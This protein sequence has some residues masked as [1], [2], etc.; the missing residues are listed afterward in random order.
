MTITKAF[1]RLTALISLLSLALYASAQDLVLHSTASYSELNKPQF[2]AD[3]YAPEGE[4]NVEG[5]LNGDSPF[6]MRLTVEARS[7][8][9]R[10]FRRSWLEGVTINNNIETL[11]PMNR[12]LADFSNLFKGRLQQGDDFRVRY[13]QDGRTVV[14]LD[15]ITLQTLS[16]NKFSP[17]LLSCWLG[18]VPLSASFKDNLIK[19][20]QD[21]D[22]QTRRDQLS[23]SKERQI[24]IQGW[25]EPA[26]S[27]T[28]AEPP[29]ITP[30]EVSQAESVVIKQAKAIETFTANSKSAPKPKTVEAKPAAPKTVI[31]KATAPEKATITKKAA[32]EKTAKV[33]KPTPSAAPKAVAAKPAV[34]PQQ[35]PEPEPV[36]VVTENRETPAAGIPA[37]ETEAILALRQQYY[38]SLIKHLKNHQTTP[39][40]A[41][42]RRWEGEVKLLVTID[43]TGGVIEHQTL[44][45]ARR[46]VFNEQAQ[47]ALKRAAPFPE[48]PKELQEETFSFTALL[49]YRLN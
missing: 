29:K 37:P 25:L 44:K 35:A 39:Y 46:K 32:P 17:L 13:T 18:D 6:E 2:I 9:S 27:T 40:M 11:Q 12:H 41:F 3:F 10:S 5:L 20:E 16:G 48:I 33:A 21:A 7:I 47:D 30:R 31:A 8:G 26:P 43:R 34:A 36:K 15:G 22:A 45:E 38:K 1:G 42:Q 24:T 23:Y 19:G 14:S 4:L 28:V 49:Q